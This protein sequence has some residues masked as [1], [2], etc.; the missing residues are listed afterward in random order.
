M[1]TEAE[2]DKALED[3]ELSLAYGLASSEATFY[4][5]LADYALSTIKEL[6]KP[7]PIDEDD[8]IGQHRCG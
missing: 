6:R 7:L 1:M 5:K 8:Y 4:A 3:V 2:V